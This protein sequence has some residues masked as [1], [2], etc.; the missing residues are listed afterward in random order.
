MGSR[1][2]N[3]DLSPKRRTLSSSRVGSPK[4]QPIRRGHR[5]NRST[6]RT[7]TR[8][9]PSPPLDRQSTFWQCVS[10]RVRRP[11]GHTKSPPLVNPEAQRLSHELCPSHPRGPHSPEPTRPGCHP[12]TR[13]I[14]QPQPNR[15]T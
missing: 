8:R 15:P 12:A 14:P 7:K 11:S 13:I 10:Q 5:F 3:V 4:E 9:H 1:T 2:G 6:P